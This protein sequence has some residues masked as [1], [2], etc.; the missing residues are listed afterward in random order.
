M[1]PLLSK[2]DSICLTTQ[3]IVYPTRENLQCMGAALIL[4]GIWTLA[5]LLASPMIFIK[6]LKQIDLNLPSSF[7]LSSISYCIEDWPLDHG[8]AYYSAFSLCIQ[9]VLP[10]LIVSA[11]Y[12]RIYGKL[13]NRIQI[14]VMTSDA[15]RERK[16]QRSRRMRRTNCLLI[17]ISVIFG[18]S[19]L[20]LNLYNLLTDISMA[21]SS[22]SPGYLMWYAVC[23]MI[24]MSSA[25]SNPLLYG[26]LNDNFRKEFKEI[27]C[28]EKASNQM[29]HANG[30]HAG[31]PPKN[32][33]ADVEALD[34]VP[35]DR[36]KLA[37]DGC[38]ENAGSTEMTVLMR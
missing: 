2:I 5:F 15:L 18:I 31:G 37:S 8:R 7:G 4:M 13:R 29:T 35:T 27:L 16:L 19:W 30:R 10:I 38:T 14:G 1:K 21:K 32:G 24:G 17:S 9:Y 26:W 22:T 3:V 28:Q 23:H 33:C 25:C 6:H 34:S 20:P 12:C 11:A 36:S